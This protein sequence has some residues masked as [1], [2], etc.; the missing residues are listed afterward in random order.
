[1]VCI[2]KALF[3]S[4]RFYIPNSCRGRHTRCLGGP[5]LTF[6]LHAVFLCYSTWFPFNNQIA[7]T[8]NFRAIALKQKSTW[9][10]EQWG[11]KYLRFFA[12]G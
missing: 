6:E 5:T 11:D 7:K 2:Y 8:L 9:L 10:I 3:K 4:S 12:F 1:M